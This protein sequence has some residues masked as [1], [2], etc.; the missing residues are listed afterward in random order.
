MARS[1][2]KKRSSHQARRQYYLL[3][4]GTRTSEKSAWEF[5]S[6]YMSDHKSTGR[7]AESRVRSEWPPPAA[8]ESRVAQVANSRV[9]S[10]RGKNSRLARNSKDSLVISE[11]KKKIALVWYKKKKEGKNTLSKL[12]RKL[13][14]YY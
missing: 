5:E 3:V 2:N 14:C 9:P 12:E 1:K 4:C 7:V 13:C 6:E 8:P 11:H 10:E